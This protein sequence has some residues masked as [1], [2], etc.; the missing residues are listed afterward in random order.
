MNEKKATKFGR[1]QY[2]TGKSSAVAKYTTNHRKAV[3]KI[4]YGKVA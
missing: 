2:R 1:Q 4:K 3:R